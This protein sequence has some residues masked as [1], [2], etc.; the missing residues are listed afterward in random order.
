MISFRYHLVSIIAVFLAL[1]LGIVVG[2]TGLNGEI[3]KGLKSEVSSLR[4]ETST[5]RAANVTLQREADSSD[6]YVSE[7]TKKVLSGTLTGR[8]VAVISAPGVP[9][10]TQTGIAT[11]IAAAGGKITARL[12]LTSA[13]VDPQRGQDIVS[14]AAGDAHPAGLQLPATSDPA[15]LGGDLLAFV[16]SG[17]GI[18]TDL[19]KV[20]AG[21]TALNMVVVEGADPMSAQLAVVLTAGTLAVGDTKAKAMPALV[22]AFS[23]AGLNTVVA[24][25]AASATGAGLVALVRADSGLT[26]TV[27]TVDNATTALGQVSTVLALAGLVVG[28]SGQYGTGPGVD[29]LFPAAAK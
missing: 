3:L 25:D 23:Q 14:L 15:I 12:Q 24:G 29:R 8:T 28:K 7:Y 11:A 27:A 22:T 6:Q 16:L 18:G 9:S 4:T 10:K 13:Y 26:R 17:Q 2:T 5:L 19:G 1:A 21:F 20:V